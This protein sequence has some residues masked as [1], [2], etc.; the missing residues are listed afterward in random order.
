MLGCIPRSPSPETEIPN[1]EAT[2]PE[3]VIQEV[4]DL[5]VSPVSEVPEYQTETDVATP[6]QARLALLERGLNVKSET[7]SAATRVKREREE[8]DN[9]GS[10]QRRRTSVKI[11]HVDL[12]DD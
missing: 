5:R 2:A 10:H 12:T 8:E 9:K 1:D 7:S 11:E 6:V 3:D 4:R